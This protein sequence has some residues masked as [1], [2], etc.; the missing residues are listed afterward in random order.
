MDDLL[1]VLRALRPLWLT[2]LVLSLAIAV[3]WG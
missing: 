3:A 2:S 1:A